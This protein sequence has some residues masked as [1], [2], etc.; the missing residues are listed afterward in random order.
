MFSIA[1]RILSGAMKSSLNH[2]FLVLDIL[3]GLSLLILLFNAD[4]GLSKLMVGPGNQWP[5]R[6]HEPWK[7]L[8]HLAPLPGLALAGTALAVLLGS[9]YI[10]RFRI[11]RRAAVFILL[12]LAL[13]PGLVVNVVLKDHLG[14]PRPRELVEFGGRHD[15]VEFWQ[16]G[17]D[18]KNSSFP[19][20]HAAIAF[21]TMAPWF[22]YRRTKPALARTFL[23][24][25][26]A[27]GCLTGIARILQGAHFI[28]D[29]VWAG[30]LVYIIGEILSWIVHPEIKGLARGISPHSGVLRSDG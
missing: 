15:F 8:Y 10:R 28:S 20:G 14:R 29:V 11:F 27:F 12:L 30:G 18:V 26:L 22:I 6:L 13:G 3:I 2:L 4:L 9:L 24:G 25:G 7:L 17:A 16:P 21:F 1:R 19:S 23:G 5:G